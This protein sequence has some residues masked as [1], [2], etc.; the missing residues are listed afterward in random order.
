MSKM[1]ET[2]H[3]EEHWAGHLKNDVISITEYSN[4]DSKRFDDQG[5]QLLEPM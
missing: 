5:V 3:S 2:W 1:C 4:H